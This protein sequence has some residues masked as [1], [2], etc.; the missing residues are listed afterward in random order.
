VRQVLGQ[1][2]S[3]LGRGHRDRGDPLDVGQGGAGGGHQ[4][5]VDVEDDLALD[6][7]VEVEDQ[8]VDDVPDRALDG[9]LQGDEPEVDG[10]LPDR[11]ED[12]DQGGEGGDVGTGV[13]RLG[14]QGL[15]GE[16]AF[17]P[18]EAD[19]HPTVPGRHRRCVVGHGQA[20]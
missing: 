6:A 8:T 10:A 15:L 11:L 16:G 7:Q 4:V 18:E 3:A 1:E 17:G 5:E 12:V 13:G 14:Q 9:V 2:P 20:G 19:P